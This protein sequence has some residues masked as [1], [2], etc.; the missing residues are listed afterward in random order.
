MSVTFFDI[1][2]LALYF[3]QCV[4]GKGDGG[5]VGRWAVCCMRTISP[6]E[7][8]NN[9]SN[10]IEVNNI[11]KKEVISTIVILYE[12]GM[13]FI[14]VDHKTIVTCLMWSAYKANHC[15]SCTTRIVDLFSMNMHAF[16][17]TIST[18]RERRGEGGK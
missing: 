10:G 18:E 9:F 7:V 16:V 1:L 2:L 6:M 12:N 4:G 5:R 3:S 13:F 11:S 8:K 17:C 15:W 14:F